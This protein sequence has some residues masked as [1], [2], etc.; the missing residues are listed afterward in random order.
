MFWA[1]QLKLSQW[2]YFPVARR[3]IMEALGLKSERTAD[4]IVAELRRAGLIV[5]R[6]GQRALRKACQYRLELVPDA[7]NIEPPAPPEERCG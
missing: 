4:K 1:E 7:V 6:G 3:D 5:R 2:G